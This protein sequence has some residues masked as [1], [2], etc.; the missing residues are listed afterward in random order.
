MTSIVTTD[1]ANKDTQDYHD[2][3]DNKK[4]HEKHVIV[5][6]TIIRIMIMIESTYKTDTADNSDKHIFHDRNSHQ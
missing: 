6:M 2:I 1:S 4:P 5:M 3:S